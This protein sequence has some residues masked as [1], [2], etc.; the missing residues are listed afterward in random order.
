MEH[1]TALAVYR[2]PSNDGDLEL[3]IGDLERYCDSRVRDRTY[4]IVGTSTVVYWIARDQRE[5]DAG[6]IPVVYCTVDIEHIRLRTE[7]RLTPVTE[8]QIEWLSSRN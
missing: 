4:W 5:E 3:F 6:A 7:F 8:Q 1:F 2:S